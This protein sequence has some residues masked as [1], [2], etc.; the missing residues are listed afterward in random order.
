VGSETNRSPRNAF[1]SGPSDFFRRLQAPSAPFR[2]ILAVPDYRNLN[3]TATNTMVDNVLI[4]EHYDDILRVAGSLLQ[5]AT[6][7]WEPMRALRSRTHFLAT[8]GRGD[9]AGRSSE[10]QDALVSACVGQRGVR[11]SL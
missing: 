6:T 7:A 3:R 4:Q 2:L 1:H 11:S 5:R 8:L 10:D 9:C